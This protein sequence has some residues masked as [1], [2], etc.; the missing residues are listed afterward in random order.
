[1]FCSAGCYLLRAESFFCNLDVIYGGLGIGKMDFLIKKNYFFLAVN[2][3]SIFGHK[4]PGYGLDPDLD[5]HSVE[6]AGSGSAYQMNTDP[7]PCFSRHLGV[8]DP[9]GQYNKIH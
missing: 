4:N 2:F 8:W 6:N 1:M 9:H 5:R 3:F 7:K